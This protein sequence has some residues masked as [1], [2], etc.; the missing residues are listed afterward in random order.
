[1]VRAFPIDLPTAAEPTV[2]EE[3]GAELAAMF[4][5]I[6]DEDAP[7]RLLQAARTLQSVLDAQAQRRR[8]N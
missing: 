6:R 4:E 1:M 8:P 2:F 7:E 3:D 5:T